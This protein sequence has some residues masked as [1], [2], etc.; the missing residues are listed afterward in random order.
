MTTQVKTTSSAVAK[1]NELGTA[2][3]VALAFAGAML[4]TVGFANSATIHDA[5]HDTRHVQTF[6][7]H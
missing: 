7:C 5:A 1:V 2:R 4:F 3:L 6:P